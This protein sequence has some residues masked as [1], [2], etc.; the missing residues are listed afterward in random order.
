M[1]TAAVRQRLF[2][3]AQ[4][5]QL[6]AYMLYVGEQPC[7]F[8]IGTLYK[9]TFYSDY[10][11]YDPKYAM[12]SPG[13]FLMMKA[14]EGM[15]RCSDDQKPRQIDFGFGDAEYKELLAT[16][17]W[18]EAVCYIYAARFSAIRLKALQTVVGFCD[19]IGRSAFSR[20]DILRRMKQTWRRRL[21]SHSA[22]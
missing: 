17:T 20:T 22:K 18:K 11:G 19:R 16:H 13:M 3:Q 4:Q 1:D 9:G 15:C 6:C 21:G 12:H 8:W 2:R 5:G 14:I 10:L 7:A